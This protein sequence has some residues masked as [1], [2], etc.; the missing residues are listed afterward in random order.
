MIKRDRKLTAQQVREIKE[1]PLPAV[2]IAHYFGVSPRTIRAIRTGETYQ[3]KDNDNR[4]THR[5]T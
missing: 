2:A 4:T 1:N 3:E 5:T